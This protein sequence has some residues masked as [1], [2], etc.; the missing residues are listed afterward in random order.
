MVDKSV[1]TSSQLEKRTISAQIPVIPDVRRL[2]E[3]KGSQLGD[4]L[5][6]Q[7]ELGDYLAK[8]YP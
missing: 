4:Q 2:T 7:S 8:S 3:R 1:K 5:G 6:L